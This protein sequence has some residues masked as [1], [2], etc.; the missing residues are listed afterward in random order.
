MT[1][2]F[3]GKSAKG[4]DEPASLGDGDELLRRH[5]PT[6]RVLPAHEG[7]ES[8]YRPVAEIDD[9]LVVK[10]EIARVEPTVELVPEL[11]AR[12]G[13]DG[14]VGE[15]HDVTPLAEALGL[16][17][18]DVDSLEELFGA[19]LVRA[20]R[21]AEAGLLHELL[22][23]DRKGLIEGCGRSGRDLVDPVD[24]PQVLDQNSSPPKRESVSPVRRTPSRRRATAMSSS[25]PTWWP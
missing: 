3:D 5:P 21:D 23:L 2:P 8:D 10:R 19:V 6:L 16:V 18:G 1:G 25:S 13:R 15:E 14:E 4:G 9:R 12:R 7:L 20:E 24:G 17:E 22:G 11:D